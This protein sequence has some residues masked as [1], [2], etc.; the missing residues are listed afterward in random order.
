MT[1]QKQLF[2]P[3]GEVDN[4]VAVRAQDQENEPRAERWNWD[5]GK[6]STSSYYGPHLNLYV[7]LFYDVISLSLGDVID[8]DHQ[9]D[10]YC[11]QI[12]F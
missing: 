2:L 12:A 4:A 8:L 3:Y 10:L 9:I 7:Q 6:K 11:D 1:S 5:G